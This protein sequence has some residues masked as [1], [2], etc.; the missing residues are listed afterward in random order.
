MIRRSYILILLFAF[1]LS[2]GQAHTE[3]AGPTK[4]LI[5]VFTPTSADLSRFE[6]TGLPAFARL[7]GTTGAYLLTGAGPEALPALDQT[8]LRYV[9]LDADL[10]GQ[11]YAATLMP[12]QPMPQWETFGT[13][14]LDD[15]VQR[16]MQMTPEQAITLAQT[17]VKLRALTLT[18]KPLTA[19]HAVSFPSVVDP[20]P[21]VQTII[22]QITTAG[23]E[24]YTGGLSG[25]WPVTIGGSP[26]TIATR[27]TYTGTPI[28]KAT[29]Y[30][31]EHLAAL[32]LDVTY[33]QWGG[34]TYPNVIGE[35][36]GQ[37]NPDDIYIIGAHLDDMPSGALAP[38]A[39]DNGSGSVATL[40][41]AD[42]FTQYNWGCTLR[43]AFWTGEE[44][45]LLGSAAYAQDAYNAGE[46]ILGY[47]NLD[48]I[49][50][51]TA[52]STPDIDL[53]ADSSLPATVTLAQL[54]A[55]VI[56]AYNLNLVPQVITNG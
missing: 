49:A 55:D 7:T 18:P 19:T 3:A 48:M 42:L 12:K 2:T 38:G 36:P 9:L 14:L 4:G 13:V 26:Y 1:L 35:L 53:H 39:D 32:G 46:N 31:G 52:A 10:T 20:D 22:D 41:A 5:Q 44:Q 50:W 43:F 25:E 34:S 30:I 11:Y 45:G 47:I 54:Y 15:G 17:G 8:G 40:L 27:N 56:D 37:T 23:I 33:D 6:A 51:N 28:Q 24:N 16:L 21:T 29:Q